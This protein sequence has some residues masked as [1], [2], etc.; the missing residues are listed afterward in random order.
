MKV[1]NL[2]LGFFASMF[3][4]SAVSAAE[5]EA[6]GSVDAVSQYICHGIDQGM[7]A[8]FQPAASL[9][10]GGLSLSAWGS[11]SIANAESKEID[12]TLAYEFGAFSVGVTNYWWTGESAPF[13]GAGDHFTEVNLNYTISESFPL[14]LSLN[15]M[16]Y[17]DL[18]A[19]GDEQYSTWFKA[20]YPFTIGSVD[21]EAAVEVTPF[22]GAYSDGFGVNYVSLRF[23]KNIVE[24]DSVTI[25]LYLDVIYSG[26]TQPNY[27]GYVAKDDMFF[28]AGISIQ[29]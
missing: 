6:S 22:E 9:A 24:T 21:C 8:S 10:Y 1:R 25:P 2:F 26:A 23:S 17:G 29:M 19:E 4:V 7:G 20:A 18:N 12:V 13:F 28:V 5:L 16:V 14:S 15:T 11:T 3:A 27:N